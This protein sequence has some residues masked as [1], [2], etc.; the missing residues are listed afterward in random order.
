MRM[1][2]LYKFNILIKENNPCQSDNNSKSTYLGQVWIVK[3]KKHLENHLIKVFMQFNEKNW[4]PIIK[5][6]S[7]MQ[8]KFKNYVV[9]IYH[10]CQFSSNLS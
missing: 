9:N 8:W 3:K 5:W 10:Y 6:I 7:D 4:E 1:P 2:S